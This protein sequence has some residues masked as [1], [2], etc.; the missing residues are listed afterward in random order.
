MKAYVR[1]SEPT[2]G[3]L[4]AVLEDWGMEDD[5]EELFEAWKMF[6]RTGG[7]VLP[8]AGGFLDQ[9]KR[10]MRFFEHMYLLKAFHA[11]PETPK[12]QLGNTW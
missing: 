4:E 8:E 10:I 11:L 1:P 12:P 2:I 7:V 6:D 3:T 9:D 5:S